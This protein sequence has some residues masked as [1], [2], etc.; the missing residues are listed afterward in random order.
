MNILA[1]DI[2]T[3]SIKFLEIRPERKN[4][5]L[6]DKTEIII[7]EARPH[8][9]NIQN[10]NELK[11]EI[12]ANFI[13]KK[14]NDTRIIFQIP[15]EFITTRYI[16]IP[17]TSKRKTE[18]II[19]FQLDEN[20]PYPLTQAHFSSRLIKKNNGFSVI[21]NITQQNIFKDFFNFFDAKDAQPTIITS[22]L[23]AVQSYIDSVRL[24]E[25]CCILDLGH[26]TSKA[27]FIQD[28]KIVSNH[29]SYIAGAQINEV[30]SKTYQIS[31]EDAIL[32]KHENSFFLTDDQFE[33]VNSEQ[34]E[35]ALLMKQLFMPLLLEFKRWEIGHRVKFGTSIDRIYIMGGSSQINGIDLFINF[36][37]KI[38]VSYLEPILEIKNDYSIHDRTFFLVKMLAISERTP[39][40]LINF[41]TG[42]FQNAS[43]AFISLHSAV[44]IWVRSSFVALLI[45]LGLFSERFILLNNNEKVLDA[46]ISS[47]LKQ[48]GQI[49][50]DIPK[51]AQKDFKKNP[52]A[53]L[54][55]FTKKN[56]VVKD[57][58]KTILSSNSINALKPLAVL[59]RSISSNPKVNL[60][61]FT[62]DGNFVKAR[63]SADDLNELMLME[64]HLKNASLYD[65]ESKLN[66]DRKELNITFMDRE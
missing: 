39:N 48:N 18:Q 60:M 17:G 42:K 52:Q 20:L 58:V 1:I 38:R 62:T 35:F 63:F 31:L 53:L 32:Y 45:L 61:N 12:V 40:S 19:P 43:N 64:K 21:S 15:N 47:I 26:K 25:T 36:H 28:R 59:S 54:K 33:D 2:G 24:N 8:Y 46:K 13:Q 27:Y 22:E 30:I 29:T 51:M 41:L 56:L 14:P 57:E 16:E 65:Y 37:T 6:L 49:T 50:Q 3:Y 9:P 44:F 23:S 66:K 7:E 5:N 10:I 55:A 11:K 4:L 34:K